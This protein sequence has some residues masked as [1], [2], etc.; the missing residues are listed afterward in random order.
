MAQEVEM[1]HTPF[2]VNCGI[3]YYHE[4]GMDFWSLIKKVV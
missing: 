4:K 1:L 3:Q 2:L